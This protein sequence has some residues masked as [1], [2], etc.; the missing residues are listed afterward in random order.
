MA[1]NVVEDGNTIIHTNGS[2]SAISAGAAVAV[3]NQIGVAHDD[4]PD[5]EDGVLHMS[6]VFSLPKTSGASTAIQP[7]EAVM[8]D[9]SANA[10]VKQAGATPATGDITNCCVAWAAAGD[11]D[12]TVDVKLNVGVGVIN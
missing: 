6:G 2:G 11:N 4:I 12:T 3:N 8:Y 5:T 7:G 10:F 9:D 1:N